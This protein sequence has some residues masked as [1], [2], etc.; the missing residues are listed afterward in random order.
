LLPGLFPPRS[1]GIIT[2][3]GKVLSPPARAFVELVQPELFAEEGGAR[4]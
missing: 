1:Y 3:K 4:R 2:R